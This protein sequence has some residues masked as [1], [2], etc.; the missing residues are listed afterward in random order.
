SSVTDR[1]LRP[2]NHR[3]LGRLL[4]HQQ[5][6][7]TQTRPPALKLSTRRFY[8]VLALVSKSCPRLKGRSSTR[9]SPVRH[10][11]RH[12]SDFLV[13]LACIRHAASVRSEPGSNSQ[14][15]I[16]LLYKLTLP[17]LKKFRKSQ[18]RSSS[19]LFLILLPKI[20]FAKLFN[21]ETN[22][23]FVK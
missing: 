2:A 4:P 15:L 17:E 11:T 20:C 19:C 9:Y 3:R 21:I 23:D 6:N 22:L 8:P 10:S 5:A 16:L 1:P 7:G 14:V 12:R 13:R 18:A